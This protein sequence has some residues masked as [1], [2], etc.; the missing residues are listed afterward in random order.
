MKSTLIIMLVLGTLLFSSCE[1]P[2]IFETDVHADGTLDK[3]IMFEKGDSVLIN[4]NIFGIDSTKG[5]SGKIVALPAEK[6]ETGSDKVQYKILFKKRFA[7][8]DQLNNE[9]N[10]TSD[11]LFH[12]HS[13]FE[14]K[15]RWFYTYITYTEAFQPINRFKMLSPADYLN[16]EDNQFIDRLP[17]EGKAISKADSLYLQM[18][19]V[20]IGEYFTNMAIFNEEFEILTELVKRS[21]LENKWMD[22]LV[23][24]KEFIYNHIEK[25]KGEPDF[26]L[27][28]ADSLH[29][30][31]NRESA[32]K[33][34]PILA[35]DLNSRISFMGFANDGKYINIIN[36]PWTVVNTNA[37]S[38]SGNRLFWR[39]LVTK[40]LFKEY[41]MYAESRKLNLWA[42]LVSGLIILLTIFFWRRSLKPR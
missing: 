23:R 42:L 3:T 19:N 22:T 10:S 8:V 15:F 21:N 36:M 9:L 40:F 38:I 4:K 18:L 16:E 11:T 32:I 7:S 37:D 2:M 29:I 26:A 41:H 5:W 6:T 13:T 20:K 33:D 35:K 39:P 28:M 14:K 25:M 34:S 24:K 1:N 17:G 31:L 12:I 30:P 27:Q